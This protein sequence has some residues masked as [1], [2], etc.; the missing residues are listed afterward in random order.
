MNVLAVETTG[1]HSTGVGGAVSKFGEESDGIVSEAK[2]QAKF[3]GIADSGPSRPVHRADA[4]RGNNPSERRSEDSAT[5]RKQPPAAEASVASPRVMSGQP[6]CVAPGATGKV[7]HTDR[8]AETAPCNVIQ[9]I[10]RPLILPAVSFADRKSPADFTEVRELAKRGEGG[11]G[12]Q[13]LGRPGAAPTPTS[14]NFFPPKIADKFFGSQLPAE[15][16]PADSKLANSIAAGDGPKSHAGAHALNLLCRRCG[17]A[18]TPRQGGRGRFPEFCGARCRSAHFNER[19]AAERRD[20]IQ[21]RRA[22]MVGPCRT[23]GGPV[24]PSAMG[25]VSRYCSARCRDHREPHYLRKLAR[26]RSAPGR[27]ARTR[28]CL[29]CGQAFRV[30]G[31]GR[32]ELCSEACARERRRAVDAVR[33]LRGVLAV[34]DGELLQL[35]LMRLATTARLLVENAPRAAA[36]RDRR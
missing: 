27:P 36:S 30:I 14:H 21:A 19:S 13:N 17:A 1:R 20:A 6:E 7:D 8:V 3:Q 16:A 18:L 4:P 12:G 15:T 26:R 31:R 25:Q 11:R 22:E 10:A 32:R 29:Q 9:E 33:R 23:C 34:Q 28:L 5:S 35:R 2:F 24:T